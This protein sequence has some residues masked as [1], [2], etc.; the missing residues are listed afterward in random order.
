[1]HAQS[2][3]KQIDDE[4]DGFS[5]KATFEPNGKKGLVVVR[6]KGGPCATADIRVYDTMIQGYVKDLKAAVE[7]GTWSSYDHKIILYPQSPIDGRQ[8]PTYI[9]RDTNWARVAASYQTMTQK[10]AL[11]QWDQKVAECLNRNQ[12][13]YINAYQNWIQ[14]N[15]SK[16]K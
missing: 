13:Q 7:G 14:R 15:I 2:Y 1:V 16:L 9:D 12:Q 4:S 3:S 8:E 5:F 11:V 6:G 10:N